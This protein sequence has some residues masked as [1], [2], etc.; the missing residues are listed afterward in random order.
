MFVCDST[1]RFYAKSSVHIHFGYWVRKSKKLTAIANSGLSVADGK[2]GGRLCKVNRMQ[3]WLFWHIIQQSYRRNSEGWSW[4]V[5]LG[6]FGL[7]WSQII[8]CSLRV[9]VGFGQVG[10]GQAELHYVRWM[11]SLESIWR[12]TSQ[13]SGC[14]PSETGR[15]SNESSEVNAKLTAEVETWYELLSWAFG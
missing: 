4:T 13:S 10:I 5:T 15:S 11:W 6:I 9:L 8:D 3:T 14:L 7:N 12:D 2:F 1:E